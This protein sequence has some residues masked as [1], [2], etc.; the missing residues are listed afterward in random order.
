MSSIPALTPTTPLSEPAEREPDQQPTPENHERLAGAL[1]AYIRQIAARAL[2][3]AA[4]TTPGLLHSGGLSVTT[5]RGLLI[6][7]CERDDVRATYGTDA[8]RGLACALRDMPARDLGT[9]I[10]GL[11]ETPAD[12]RIFDLRPE[13][14]R[15]GGTP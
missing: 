11:A 13:T 2:R 12:V 4:E 8:V 14:E 10:A 6:R 9:L 7:W 3:S 15:E 1:A 5:L